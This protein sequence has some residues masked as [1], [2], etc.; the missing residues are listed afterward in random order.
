MVVFAIKQNKQTKNHSK[1]IEQ[2]RCY[3]WLGGEGRPPCEGNFW[4]ETWMKWE[5]WVMVPTNG[6]AF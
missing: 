6:Q 3:Y 1:L 4:L 2:V 5:K